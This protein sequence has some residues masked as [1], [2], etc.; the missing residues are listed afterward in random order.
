LSHG[1]TL[2]SSHIVLCHWTNGRDGASLRLKAL[3]GR[4]AFTIFYQLKHGGISANAAEDS[5]A[6]WLIFAGP[7]R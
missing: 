5:G 6:A 4:G 1:T 3:Q 7:I 2:P